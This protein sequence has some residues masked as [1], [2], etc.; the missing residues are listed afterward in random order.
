MYGIFKKA[1][2]LSKKEKD[3]SAYLREY[4]ENNPKVLLAY[5]KALRII[6]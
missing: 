6:P 1:D 4:F 3:F 5:K 2:F